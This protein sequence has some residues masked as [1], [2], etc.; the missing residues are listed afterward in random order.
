V[1]NRDPSEKVLKLV[2]LARAAYGAPEL[3]SLPGGQIRSALYCPVGRSL[4]KGVEDWLFVTVGSKH[5][6]LWAVGKDPVTI[7]KQIM[8]AWGMSH[9]QPKPS[10]AS[11]E[12]VMVPLP[13]ELR[14]F[15]HRF[16]RGLLPNLEGQID[17]R[18]VHHLKDLANSMPNPVRRRSD[19]AAR[20]RGLL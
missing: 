11:P 14:E 5:L 7:A 19:A 16:D 8:T 4:R 9:E 18:E 1:D 17:Q 20:Q 12:I 6:R 3:E 15:L 10:R 13:Y 2:N